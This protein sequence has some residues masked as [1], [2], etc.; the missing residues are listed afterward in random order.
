MKKLISTSLA[1]LLMVPAALLADPTSLVEELNGSLKEILAPFNNE[2][3]SAAAH[4]EAAEVNDTQVTYMKGSAS[5]EKKAGEETASL[6]VSGAYDARAAQP[7]SNA[8][9]SLKVN[10]LRL[11]QGQEALNELGRSSEE[12]L[13]GLLLD[14]T[15]QYGDAATIEVR[16][17][18]ELL[19]SEGNLQM[20]ALEVKG[21]VDLSKLPANVRSEEVF[22]LEAKINAKLTLTAV[23]FEVEVAHNP[24][25]KSGSGLRDMLVSVAKRD[26][27][28]MQMITEKFAEIDAMIG[29]LLEGGK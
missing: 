18:D 28:V 8:K 17:T 21:K 14:L 29:G 9:I 4:F 22:L 1:A 15:T 19:D 10:V 27:A 12:M 5:Y 23:E 25:F 2:T 20:Q 7:A 16:K 13:A 3:T 26:Q 11:V 24:A 6:V